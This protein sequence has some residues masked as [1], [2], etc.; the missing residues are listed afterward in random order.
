[1]GISGFLFLEVL[2]CFIG[3][4]YSWGCNNILWVETVSEKFRLRAIYWILNKF[5]YTYGI[6]KFNIILKPV[7]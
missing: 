2:H 3:Q 4:S 5:Q 1:M 6:G 7:R